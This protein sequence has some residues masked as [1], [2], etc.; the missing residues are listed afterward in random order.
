MRGV[1]EG[2]RN[3]ASRLYVLNGRLLVLTPPSRIPKGWAEEALAGKVFENPPFDLPR[4]CFLCTRGRFSFGYRQGR[5]VGCN[6]VLQLHLVWEG[7]GR[8]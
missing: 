4:K 3:Q 2:K 8:I 5:H 6:G 1:L 7:E